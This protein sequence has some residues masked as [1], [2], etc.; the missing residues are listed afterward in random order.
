TAS[1]SPTTTVYLTS[2]LLSSHT[3]S[4]VTHGATIF[5]SSAPR[6]RRFEA[7]EPVPELSGLSAV[8]VGEEDSGHE[9]LTWLSYFDP[10][11]PYVIP[12]TP[13][14]DGRR[15]PVR[16]L[17]STVAVSPLGDSARSESRV[18]SYRARSLGHVSLVSPE[19]GT[20]LVAWAA[21][22]GK[23]PQLFATLVNERGEKAR[24]KMLTRTPG[25]VSDVAAVRV[26]DGYMIAWVDGRD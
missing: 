17:L 21:V 25:E 7:L 9:L 14:P 19:A 26:A 11:Q 2:D 18:L 3:F 23:D 10:D 16:A 6:I 20:G 4:R 8:R 22:D 12:S 1:G 5:D 15:A 13:A 24:Q